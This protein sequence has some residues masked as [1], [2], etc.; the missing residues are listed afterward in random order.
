ML[1]GLAILAVVANH[2]SHSGFT[3]MFWWTDRYQPVSVPNYDQMGSFSYYLLVV[4]QKL[5]LFSVPTFLF[6][7]G[8]FLAYAARG[9][10]SQ[11]TWT[12]IKRRVLNLLPPYLIW[13]TV[14]FVLQYLLGTRLALQDYLLGYVSIEQ[15]PYFF[16]PLVILYYL[17]SPFLAPLAK[18]HWKLVLGLG[19]L[20]LMLGIARSYLSIYASMPDAQAPAWIESVLPF[21]PNST[22]FEFFFYYSAGL[23][24]GFYQPQLKEL[25]AKIKW[26][27]LAAVLV[28]S[29]LAVVEAEWVF[30]A[31]E[32][33]WRSRTL[34]LPTA[35]YAITFVLT[36]LAFDQVRLPFAGLLYQLGVDT[37]GIYLLHKSV[38]LVLPKIVY[39]ALPFVLGLQVLYQPLLIG[40][41]V[42]LPILLMLITRQLPVRKHYRAIFG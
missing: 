33:S 31:T 26:G 39:H 24:A 35:L 7:T 3:A 9:A 14:Y 6:I 13:T 1:N 30:R 23:V 37:L 21:L 15:S 20:I 32:I 34:T 41:A 18:N 42:G 36:F 40:F 27:L 29:V 2:A 4:L 8:I 11:L 10:Q 12:V 5:A 38:L 16:I 17:L 25:L 28:M 22:I 19:G